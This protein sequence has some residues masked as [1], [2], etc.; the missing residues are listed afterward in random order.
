MLYPNPHE[1][2]LTSIPSQVDLLSSAKDSPVPAY[3]TELETL[4]LALREV[5]AMVDRVLEYVQSVTSGKIQGDERV[6]RQLLG[7][8]SATIEG[9]EKDKLES[10]FNSHLQVR[11]SSDSMACMAI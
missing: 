8:L 7:T 11:H 5:I 6:G 9:L 2:R 3:A 1:P 10:L 4:E